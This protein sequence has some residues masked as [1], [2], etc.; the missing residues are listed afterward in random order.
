MFDFLFLFI[1]CNLFFLL[2]VCRLGLYVNFITVRQ[3]MNEF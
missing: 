2:S 1:S 3:K